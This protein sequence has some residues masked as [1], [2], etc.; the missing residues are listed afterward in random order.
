MHSASGPYTCRRARG[1]LHLHS[2]LRTVR[3]PSATPAFP[4]T[5][6]TAG[7]SRV[8][9]GGSRAAPA[10]VRTWPPL[11]AK[12][13]RLLAVEILLAE[14]EALGDDV[15]ESCLYILRES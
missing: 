13:A 10:S 2:A 6:G 7:A 5:R 3:G 14:P 12:A 4:P 15:L 1:R 9:L 11:P 8:V